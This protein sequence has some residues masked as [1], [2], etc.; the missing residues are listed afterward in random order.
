MYI[1]EGNI[2]VGKSTFLTLTEQLDP[3]IA[4]SLEPV[5]NWAGQQYGQSLL[6]QF[7]RNPKRWA[8][9]LETL[10]MICRSRD[11]IAMQ[12]G[13][14]HTLVER[15]IYSGH[16]C[17][18]LNGHQDG[19]FSKLEWDLYSQWVD[20]LFSE[21]CKLPHGFIYLRAEPDVCHARTQIRNRGGEEA[22]D[23]AYL[24]K[25]HAWHDK[26]LLKKEGIFE[27]L[28]QVPVLVLDCTKEFLANPEVMLGH[29]EKMRDFI[30]KTS[31]PLANPSSQKESVKIV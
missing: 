20:F 2:G 25:I 14:P 6:E 15:S 18:A 17:F 16:Y 19:Y 21:K 9:T 28:K 26:F 24:E 22:L 12:K 4:C 7:Y 23:L 3:R 13:A 30:S 27:E 29:L 31:Q 8:Y 5:D 11:H 10:A 1:I